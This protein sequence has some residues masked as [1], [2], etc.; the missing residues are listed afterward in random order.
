MR[1]EN[2]A[3]NKFRN[4]LT[5]SAYA[6]WFARNRNYLLISV[7]I[8]IICTLITYP[9]V[10]YSDSYSRTYYADSLRMTLHAFLTG[11]AQAYP[12]G[13]W[14]T[15][16]PSFF[17]LLSKTIVGSIVLFTITQSLALWFFSFV[18]TEQLNK[19]NH[20]IRIALCI[21][22]SPVMWA[23]GVFYEAGVGSAI[24]IL[25]ILLLIW[26][27]GSLRSRFDKTVSIILLFISSFICFGFRANA[28]S[29]LPALIIIALVKEKKFLVRYALIVPVLLGCVLSWKIPAMLN[30][31][32]MPS[33]AAGFAW[34]TVST[35][36][37]MEPEKREEYIDYLDDIFGDGATAS[38]VNES[39][40]D[41]Q[42]A[43][44]NQ[45]FNSPVN[46][47][48]L[49][50][51]GVSGRV[52]KKY[53]VLAF[54]EPAAFLK[55]KLEFILHTMGIGKTVNMFEYDYNRW[56]NMDN[57]GYNNSYNR[58]VFVD[59]FNAYMQSV[60]ILRMPWIWYLA[61]LIIILVYR[62]RSQGKN[63]PLNL[64]EASYI[65]SVF[66]YGAYL[67]NTQSFEFRYFFPSWLLL[68]LIILSLTDKLF[69]KSR[70]SSVVAWVSFLALSALSYIGGYREYV[71]TG[72]N[73]ISEIRSN[74]V[75]LYSDNKNSV[76]YSDQNL[77]FT[78]DRNSDYVYAYYVEY[79]NDS[80]SISK[81]E[82]DYLERSV[83]TAFGN[84]R[85]CVIEI[86]AQRISG[87][88]FGQR[89]NE[90]NIWEGTSA[91]SVFLQCPQEIEVADRSGDNWEKGYDTANNVLLAEYKG[92]EDFQLT[93]KYMETPDGSKTLIT[94]V[95]KA[96]NYL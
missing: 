4:T 6:K 83:P 51:E 29:I 20:K 58:Q 60:V 10:L 5:Q 3:I 53:A 68:F 94:G 54:N 46:T 56:D 70:G 91:A 16:T 41:D 77:Y 73:L 71:R 88:T 74:A 15:V 19:Q 89:F 61:A 52:I 49:S 55:T 37:T 2:A 93:G 69:V 38:A 67:L 78:A 57:Y 82:F 32:T 48:T 36:Q 21:I 33:Y 9:G 43:N 12:T 64:Y 72:D 7:F 96:G 17:I 62:F 66:Y 23:F 14:I 84:D 1:K 31:Y 80:G 85:I 44:I 28:V 25:M 75:L 86:P 40:Y 45:L 87:I 59:Y 90:Y 11:N 27:W 30:I 47:D 50:G 13:S 24:S 65:V 81:Y 8:S 92:I 79:E 63:S 18:F 76:Y 39:Q 42:Y 35:I 95:E 22:V 26:K 34:E